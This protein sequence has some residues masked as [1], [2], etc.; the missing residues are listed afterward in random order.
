[1]DWVLLSLHGLLTRAPWACSSLALF[2][3]IDELSDDYMVE[4]TSRDQVCR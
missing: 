4:A 1:M 2:V 3:V